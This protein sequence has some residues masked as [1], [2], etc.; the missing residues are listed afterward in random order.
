MKAVLNIEQR[1]AVLLKMAQLI[2]K[3][4]ETLITANQKDLN[5]YAGEEQCMTD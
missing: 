2:T 3:N 1:N 4:K 5:S